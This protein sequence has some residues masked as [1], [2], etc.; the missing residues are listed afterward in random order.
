MHLALNS[1][2]LM[3]RFTN[4]LF[5][6]AYA[7]VMKSLA[8]AMTLVQGDNTKKPTLLLGSSRADSNGP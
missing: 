8:L 5:L 7:K 6:A 4:L 1:V 3:F 2:V